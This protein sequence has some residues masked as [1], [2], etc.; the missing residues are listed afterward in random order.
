MGG[1]NMTQAFYKLDNGQLLYA[2]NSVLH[3]TYEL[4]ADQQ[5]TYTYPVDGWTWFE[6]DSVAR[7]HFGLPEPQ[8]EPVP[9]ATGPVL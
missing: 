2:P 9:G 7:A 8:P 6:S 3:A 4:H 5:A 1:Y